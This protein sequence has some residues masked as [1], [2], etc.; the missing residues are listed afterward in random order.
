MIN[1]ITKI[2]KESW[3]IIVGI[4]VL[5]LSVLTLNKIRT[6]KSIEKID[7]KINENEKAVEKLEGK[8]EQIKQQKIVVKKKVV[9]KKKQITKTKQQLKKKPATKKR[10]TSAAKKNIISK[11]KKK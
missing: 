5:V 2:L 9:A 1:R 3:K 8:V 10:T 11:T 4:I 6:R 7:K